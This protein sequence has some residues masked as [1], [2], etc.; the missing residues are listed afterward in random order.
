MKIP[1]DP[2]KASALRSEVDSLLEEG[3]DYLN[4]QPFLSPQLL[5]PDISGPKEA[6]VLETNH[7][8][9]TPEY[10]S[11]GS[12]FQMET[13]RSIAAAIQP[14][15]WAVSLDL[16]DAYF[17]VPIHKD[18]RHFLRF[19]F[20][21]QVYE[22]KALPFG[23]ASAP[24]VFH[25][26]VKVFIAPFRAMGIKIH[27]YLDDW[28]I[29]CESK[30][31]LKY[32]LRVMLDQVKLAGWIVNEEKSEMT[33]SQDFTFIGI[34]FCTHLGSMFPPPDRIA[35]ILLE[36]RK[37]AALNFT[38]ARNILSFLGLVNSASAQIPRG[39]LYARPLQL[40]LLSRWRP[41]SDPLEEHISLP[42]DLLSQVW[43]FWGSENIL[44]LGVL[45]RPP[46]PTLSLFTDASTFG[47]GAHVN[48]LELTTKGRWSGEESRMS[49]NTLE[50]KAVLL[51][52]NRFRIQ[53]R[54]HR[55][56]LFSDNATVVAYI[57]KQGGTHSPE[58]C[59]LTWSLLQ[60]CWQ[61][62]I[63][64]VPRHIPGKRNILA[65]ALS[66]SNKLVSTEWPLHH[67]I[68]SAIRE[69]WDSP[70]IDLFATKMNFRLPLYMSPLPDPAAVAV[71]ALAVPWDG[72][73]AYAF[74]PT[75][76]L[77]AVLNKVA[78]SQLRLCLI[79]PCWPNQAWFPSLMELL[80]DHPRRIPPW[81]HLL[82]HPIGR[83]FHDSPGSY[84]LHAWRLSGI[85]SDREAFRKT[86]SP[87]SLVLRGGEPLTDIN[88]NGRY[89]CLG[90]EKTEFIRSLPLFPN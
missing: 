21:G 14:G 19:S 9:V 27:Y 28:L 44:Q 56:S 68:V 49:I 78:I 63:S 71:D 25:T 33:P 13:T 81:D 35:K 17:H 59:R 89:T 61:E 7:R 29:R 74:P 46:S 20:E 88:P 48:E 30:E 51:A 66:R 54:G 40:L 36:T 31:R 90:V 39:R 37:L 87:E 84:R 67:D 73:N 69:R 15:D 10:L 1:Q 53:L 52:V 22:F 8:P 42:Q 5:Q 47:W 85:S 58:L 77:Q 62:N 23:L 43:D 86:L 16:K 60:Y 11:S 82:W 18:F 75:P 55:V 26:I 64:L 65:H 76:L 3:S 45:L 83:V 24:L 34:R 2:A 80:M 70:T 4:R 38:T 50:L 79:A 41:H 12:P 72:L 6:G 32:L 57:R